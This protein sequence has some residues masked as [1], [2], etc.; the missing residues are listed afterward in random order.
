[1]TA[2]KMVTMIYPTWW[3]K[4]VWGPREQFVPCELDVEYGPI[5]P[6]GGIPFLF[7]FVEGLEC[8]GDL[9]HFIFHVQKRGQGFIP[10]GGIN[11]FGG[12]AS[13]SCHVNLMLNVVQFIHAA[14][15]HLFPS[16]SA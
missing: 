4:H 11:M 3:D 14:E 9:F 2:A 16:R 1:M 5:H 12:P 13:S 10:H 8:I 7:F 6:C 15:Y